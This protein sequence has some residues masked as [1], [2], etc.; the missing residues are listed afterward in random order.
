MPGSVVSQK[1]HRRHRQ[2]ES[3]LGYVTRGRPP[4][5]EPANHAFLARR[6]LPAFFARFFATFGA[7]LAAGLR[8]DLVLVFLAAIFVCL[9]GI[10]DAGKIADNPR[11]CCTTYIAT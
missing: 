3:E 5:S 7:F 1:A 9:P 4:G 11:V 6:F 2:P 8:A 10:R